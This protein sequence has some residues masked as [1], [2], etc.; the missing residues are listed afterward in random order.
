MPKTK[1]ELPSIG[2]PVKFRIEGDKHMHEGIYTEK[3]FEHCSGF[4]CYTT[5]LVDYWRPMTPPRVDGST[6]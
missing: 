4:V 2:T 6:K 5:A 1:V 3:G